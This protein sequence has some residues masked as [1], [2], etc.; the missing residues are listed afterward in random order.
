M[1]QSL[2]MVDITNVSDQTLTQVEQSTTPIGIVLVRQGIVLPPPKQPWSPRPI[3]DSF[4]LS[5]LVKAYNF[6]FQEYSKKRKNILQLI[7]SLV[8]KDVYMLYNSSFPES[9]FSKDTLRDRLR[10]TSKE[11]KTS[12]SNIENADTVVLQDDDVLTRLRATNNH[13]ACNILK[14][15]TDLINAAKST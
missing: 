10:E 5:K 4:H 12:T 7:P 8:W 11:L 13:A 14:I 2:S 3:V 6:Y 1:A 9:P 15:R